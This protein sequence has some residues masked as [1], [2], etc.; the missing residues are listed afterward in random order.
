ML[1]YD[2]TNIGW[3]Q[4]TCVGVANASAWSCLMDHF[5]NLM[6]PWITAARAWGR[7]YILTPDALATNAERL[8]YL[9]GYSWVWSIHIKKFRKMST[10]T[11]TSTRSSSSSKDDLLS[12]LSSLVSPSEIID[13]SSPEYTNNS[14]IWSH[15][16]YQHPRLV[17]RP[18]SL[19]SLSQI[20]AFLGKTDLD[21]KVRSQGYGNAT[22]KDVLI[23]LTAFDQFAW[24]EEN[25]IVTL[26]AGAP[27]SKYYEEIS[28]AA[29]DYAS[30]PPS[31]L[32]P[33]VT[34]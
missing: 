2:S 4:I 10:T 13:P 33:R 34:Y 20:I 5:G 14:Q 7:K 21:F 1:R 15:A 8:F 6:S 22:A 25:K 3:R 27:W 23:S 30:K 26:G 32:H 24:D 19:D 17:L 12:H 11:T 16:H 31:S 29:P 9:K 28:K 18:T